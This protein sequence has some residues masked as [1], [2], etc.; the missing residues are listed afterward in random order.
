MFT[1][2]HV[3]DVILVFAS[4]FVFTRSYEI[5]DGLTCVYMYLY[6]ASM[7]TLPVVYRARPFLTQAY[8]SA[9]IASVAISLPAGKIRCYDR[10]LA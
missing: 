3:S 9:A 8:T 1:S 2:I 4:C 7:A 6:S 10:S 5:Y